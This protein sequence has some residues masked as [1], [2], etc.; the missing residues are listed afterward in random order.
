MYGGGLY[1]I[2]SGYDPALAA[3]SFSATVLQEQSVGTVV[4]DYA[5]YVLP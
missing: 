3:G 2:G 5:V 1:H 4:Q